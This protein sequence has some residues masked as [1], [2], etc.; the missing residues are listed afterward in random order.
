M[1]IVLLEHYGMSRAGSV[2]DLPA[3]EA[4][5]LIDTG[6]A[7]AVGESPKAAPKAKPKAKPAK[8]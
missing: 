8:K 7:A 5:R 2:I 3:G 1:K 6:N 4:Q